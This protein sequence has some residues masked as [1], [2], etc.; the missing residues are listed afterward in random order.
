MAEEICKVAANEYIVVVDPGQPEES[1]IICNDAE[2][3]RVTY[4][5]IIIDLDVII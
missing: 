4:T 2:P 3:W 5:K 1:Y